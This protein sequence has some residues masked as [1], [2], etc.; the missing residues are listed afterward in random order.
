MKAFDAL[1]GGDTQSLALVV[2]KDVLSVETASV[3]CV[4]LS[5]K[6]FP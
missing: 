5:I 4:Q 2:Y 6:N 1:N 3:H